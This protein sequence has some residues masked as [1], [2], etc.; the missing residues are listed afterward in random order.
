MTDID[1]STAALAHLGGR[2]V[3][4]VDASQRLGHKSY[5]MTAHYAHDVSDPAVALVLAVARGKSDEGDVAL[6]DWL[7]HNGLDLATPEFPA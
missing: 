4:L 5:A 7:A 1:A 6:A 2:L 3:A